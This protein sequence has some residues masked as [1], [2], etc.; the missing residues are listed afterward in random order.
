MLTLYIMHE[1]SAKNI[2]HMRKCTLQSIKEQTAE[3]LHILLNLHFLL[4]PA[5]R[6][7]QLLRRYRFL[8]L[9]KLIEKELECGWELLLVLDLD[10]E[11]EFSKVVEGVPELG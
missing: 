9:K 3:L 5:K 8:L 4:C 6:S 7:H 11:E 2:T 1:L 10:R